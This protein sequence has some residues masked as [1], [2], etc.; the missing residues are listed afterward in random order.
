MSRKNLVLL[1]GGLDSS[2]LLAK[3]VRDFGNENTVAL[4]LYYGQKHHKELECAR[5]QAAHQGVDLIEE[6]LSAVFKFNKDSAL[7]LESNN[8][9]PETSYAS[10]LDDLGGKG[11]VITYVPFRNGLFLS[12]ATAIALQAKCGY[13]YYG[14]H[15]DDAAGEAYPDCTESFIR[16]MSEAIFLGSGNKVRLIAP[17]SDVN[18]SLIVNLG[19]FLEVDYANTW[20]C[21]KGEEKPCGICGTCRDRIAAF[22]SN[23]AEDPL[24][25]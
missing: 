6:D 21:Y 25:Y 1:S 17:F 7:L 16:A 12:Y 18:K 10:Q 9:I 8:S 15:A 4:C 19:L 24:R 23:G 20:S 11:T 22:K 2:T 3:V 14:A 13:I 5:I